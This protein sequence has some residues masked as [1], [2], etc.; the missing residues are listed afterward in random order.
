MTSILGFLK[1][2]RLSI[3]GWLVVSM[4]LAIGVLVAALKLQG[5]RLHKAKLKLIEKEIDVRDDQ[6]SHKVFDALE[7][8]TK[9]LKDFQDAG[10][11]I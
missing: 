2:V 11:K 7:K 8:Y 9:S 3:T 6:D 10:G 4:G 1:G 5:S